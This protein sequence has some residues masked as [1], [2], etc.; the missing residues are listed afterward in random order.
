M[1]TILQVAIGISFVF[2]L[3]SVIVSSA[4]E[5]GQ[6]RASTR[7]KQLK[8]GI[9]ALLQDREFAKAAKAFW[10]HPLISGLY[11]GKDGRPFVISLPAH[12]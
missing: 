5:I 7:S 4:N 10:N 1:L 6:A 3:F 12:S 8:A 2:L 11:K 9:G